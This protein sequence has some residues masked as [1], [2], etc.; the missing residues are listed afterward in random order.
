[1]VQISPKLSVCG[2]VLANLKVYTMILKFA[3]SPRR[4]GPKFPSVFH[5]LEEACSQC[6]FCIHLF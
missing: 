6:N 2:L 1:M 3:F 5:L 4:K